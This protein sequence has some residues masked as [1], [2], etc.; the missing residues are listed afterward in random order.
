LRSERSF[1]L[2][3]LVI[4]ALTVVVRVVSLLPDLWWMWGTHF[5]RF[6]PVYVL[7]VATALVVAVVLIAWRESARLETA[8]TNGLLARF[9]ARQCLAGA[10]VLTLVV[11]AVFWMGRTSHTYL[12]DGNVIANEISFKQAL[13]PRQPLTSLIQIHL[14]RIF[15]GWFDAEGRSDVDISQDA[16]AVSSVIAGLLFLAGSWLLAREIV[17]GRG[18]DTSRRAPVVL[19]VWMVLAL[20]G[21]AQL[22]FG[23][24]ENYSFYAA[25]L[26]FYLWTGIR[27]VRGEFPL[28]VP[29]LL[30]VLALALHLSAAILLASFAVIVASAFAR[31]GRRKQALLDLCVLAGVVAVCQYA[32]STANP[33]YSFIGSLAES[34]R[35]VATREQESIPGY[36]L[37]RMHVRDFINEQLLIGPLGILLFL[38]AAGI[39]LARSGGL[40]DREAW[41]LVGAG[42][43]YFA[44]CWV[45][46]DS[47]LG[48]A[49][50]WDLFAPAGIV[51][52][53]GALAMFFNARVPVHA[54]G[55]ALV[56][57][58]AV[59]AYH[60]IPWI[61]TNANTG[62]SLARLENLPLGLG[63]TEVL[64]ATWYQRRGDAV[65]QR[66][67]LETAVQV[68]PYNNNA[69]SLLGILDMKERRYPEAV[70][71]LSN[72]VKLRPDKLVFR[73]S[74]VRAL[75]SANRFEEAIPHMEVLLKAQ[76][77]NAHMWSGYGEALNR[78]KRT[79][80]SRQAF[81]RAAEL[82]QKQ[83]D[84]SPNDP[85]LN[86]AYGW[87]LSAG[88]H[89]EEALVYIR[90]AVTLDPKLAEAHCYLGDVLH[91]L[92][93][94]GEA[95]EAYSHC[96][97]L[98][99]A[100]P[101]R[102]EIDSLI[103]R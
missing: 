58:L 43:F 38:P 14:Y 5:Y 44:A 55:A 102:A 87:A 19:L 91:R 82:Y 3:V 99:P 32:L 17:R 49:R 84:Q 70:N 78:A 7:I 85:G 98:N 51:F 71:A 16:V 72:A 56:C 64:L 4:A 41:F 53:A 88:G 28:L 15:R 33:G 8:L 21:Y 103:S 45:A 31:P 25:T 79:Q 68:H 29:G 90:K 94:D 52:T 39:A 86:F 47:N 93:R 13:H 18:E 59:S 36:M 75:Y 24:V 89:P 62:R 48:Y 65:M 2:S 46:G 80:E 35:L 27:S 60:T 50:N 69:W 10:V 22:F 63:R 95:A 34:T 57:A 96:I 76:P 23:Y 37:S 74:L 54:A 73:D 81:A 77:E 100:T 42:V 12:G 1:L 66:R 9:S 26:V 40:R 61:A 101:R 30:L 67:W 6:F 92:G 20:Q 83:L 97:E 11:T